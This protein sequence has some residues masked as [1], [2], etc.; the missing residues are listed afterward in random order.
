[1]ITRLERLTITKNMFAGLETE[2]VDQDVYDST[3]RRF[4]DGSTVSCLFRATTMFDDDG[5]LAGSFALVS[6]IS[7]IK[8]AHESLRGAKEAAERANQAKSE[9]LSSMS[10]ELRTPLNS[11]IG[12]AQM[13]EFS[14]GEVLS[15]TQQKCATHILRGGNHLLA[16]INDVLDLAKIE[17]GRIEMSIEKVSLEHV[18]DDNRTNIELME[19]IVEQI[20]GL[21]LVT[22]TNGE[23]G[24]VLA[25][26]HDPDLIVLDI[27]LPGMDGYQVLA[28]LKDMKRFEATPIIAFSAAATSSDIDA[29][30]KAGFIHYLTKPIDV[31]E[32]VKLIRSLAIKAKSGN[33]I[34]D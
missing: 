11:V 8:Q 19:M 27:N 21:A 29:A 33:A 7:E 22:A 5:Q 4:R 6:D 14:P 18:I 1:M 12:F 10:H 16:L 24:L 9:F 23:D 31:G 20:P 17:A 26:S 15:A 28:Q 3:V 13:M 25:K 30:I 32:A 34:I 2:I